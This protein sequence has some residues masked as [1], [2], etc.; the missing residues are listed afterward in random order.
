M[1]ENKPKLILCDVDGTLI[2]STQSIT[3]AFGK[4]KEL[5]SE[6]NLCFSLASG[7]SLE[8]LQM[9]ADELEIKSPILINNGAG[10]RADGQILWDEFFPPLCV[11]DAVL[12]ADKLDMAIFM[13]WGDK[14]TVFRHNAYVQN[15]IE[16]Y[17]RYNWFYIP[18]ESEWPSLKLERV[19]ITDPQRPGRI[20]EILPY[21][22]PYADEI[23]IIR[24]DARHVDVMKKGVSKGGAIRRLANHLGIEMEDIMAIGDGVNDTEMLSM[25]GT[26]VAV[27]NANE[28]LKE[29]A[30]YVCTGKNTYGVIEA[31]RKF[32]AD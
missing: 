14:E 26:G 9:Y 25:V 13:C 31:V 16:R 19:M 11:K 15:E 6:N 5:I 1:K 8:C 27:G 7:R 24:Y 23:E 17:H 22:E 12:A 2:D 18:L 20:D 32:C 29:I 4:L 21:L 3:P 10:A 30:D 28:A